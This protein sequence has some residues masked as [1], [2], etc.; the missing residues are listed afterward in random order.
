MHEVSTYLK[1]L[2]I[3]HRGRLHSATLHEGELLHFSQNDLQL[4]LLHRLHHTVLEIL[5][6]L[7]YA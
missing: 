1:T 6:C 3:S 2:M 4:P 7:H 5:S